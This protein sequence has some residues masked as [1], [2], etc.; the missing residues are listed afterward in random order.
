[1]T[2]IAPHPF[3]DPAKA[4]AFEALASKTDS[5]FILRYF[6]VHGQGSVIRTLIAIGSGI[7][8]L[9]N[10]HEGD[11]S[12][13]RE[14][15]P[16]GVM[17]LLTETSADGKTSIQIAESD[18][19]ERYLARKF[20]LYGNG[21]TFEEVLVNTFAHSSQ[22]VVYDVFNK[23][24]LFEDLTVREAGKKSLIEDSLNRW[25]KY[26]EQH[27][28]A[29]GANGHY[30]GNKTTLADVRTDYV[31]SMILGITG[32]ELISESKTPA[33]WKVREE[34]SKI[35]GVAKWRASEEWKSID[36]ENHDMLG[37]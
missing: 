13:Y 20:G 28:Q 32:D 16:F 15:T 33:L 29:N 12:T 11:W 34:I 17:P 27:L 19:I 30:V 14:T 8:N 37:Y 35:P 23:Y 1:M 24:A 18:A 10:I 22:C 2:K 21:S 4:A 36:K 7:V 5:T 3:F 26:H 25:I 9:T 31:I 6:H